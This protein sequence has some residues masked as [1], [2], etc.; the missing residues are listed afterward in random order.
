MKFCL[1]AFWLFLL[2]VGGNQQQLSTDCC[3]GLRPT[4]GM[5]V[6][7]AAAT[8][9]T[10]V[11]ATASAKQKSIE[12]TLMDS[13]GQIHNGNELE[14][15]MKLRETTR[16]TKTES[17]PVIG[18]ITTT[19]IQ[20]QIV[21]DATTLTAAQKS[22]A[23]QTV[24]QAKTSSL[25]LQQNIKERLVS[26]FA[27]EE[28]VDSSPTTTTS[29]MTD[30]DGTITHHPER[31]HLVPDKLQYTKEIQ[32]KQ[33]RLMGITR[34]FQ[35]TSGLREVDQYLGLP[36]A[37]APTG[38]RRF[39]PPGAPLPWQGLKIARHLPPVCPQK[40]PDMSSQNSV[41]ISRGRYKHLTRLMP[42][43]K[44][45]SEDCLYLNL[46]VPHHVALPT[47]SEQYAVLVY[48]HGESF[49]WNSG[50]PYDGSVLAS[51]GGVIVVTVNY[52]L[53][54][55]GFM[56]PSID[57][58]NIANYA[59]LDQMA[60]L[61][62]IKENIA[63]F[64]GDNTRV[65]LMG[66]STGAACVNYLMVSPV[67]S[68]LFHRAI[69]MSGS[70]MS[71]WA[72]SNQS[73]QLTM[74]IAHA[75]D[76]PLSDHEEDDALLEC[77]RQRRYQDIL[78]IPTSFQQFSTSLGPIV[79]G[80]VIPNQPYKVMA[81]NTEYFSRYDL[82]FGITESESYHTL[83][84]LAL[85]EGLRENERDNLLR[86]YMQ[87]RFD[88]RP[89]LALAATLKKYQDMYNNP[90][91]ATNL[92][93]RDVVL[94]ILSDARVVGPLLQTGVFHADVHRRNYMYV[95]GHNSATGPYANLPHSIM[96]E[97]LAF[98][99]GAPLA[100]AG[101]FASHNYS[102]QEKL[103]SEAVMA[104]WTNFVKSG[105]PKAPWKGTFLNSHALEWDRYDLDWPEFNKRSQAYLNI[106]IPPTVG[107]KYRQI[108]MNF[109]NKEL[110]DE[111]NQIAAIQ[112]Q[113]QQ[114]LRG[115]LTSTMPGNEVITGHMS[116]YGPRD[117]GAE[118][119]VRT[120]K[121]LLQDPLATGSEQTETA[122]ENMYNAP[123]TFG[124]VHRQQ[125]GMDVM[126]GSMSG[127]EVTQP[128]QHIADYGEDGTASPSPLPSEPVA[129]SETTMQLLI[130]LIAIFIVLNVAI[131]AT[132]LLRQRRK[133]NTS[134]QRK[135]GGNI[136]SYDGANDDELKRCSKSRDGDDSYVLD[137]VRK[138][139][140]Y[141]AIKTG[142]R[143]P[144]NGY[145]IQRQLSSSTVDT[146]TKVCEW[147]SSQNQGHKLPKSGSFQTTPT[148]PPVAQTDGRI[149]ICQDI[150][151]A[152]AALLTPQHMHE[153][154]ET[155]HYEL[156][157]QRQHS[158]LT[159]PSDAT[160][161]RRHSHSHSDPVDMI[162]AADEQVTSFVHADDVDINVTS[163][164]EESLNLQP[165]TAAQQLDLLR[166]RN[167]P[168]VLPTAQDL[169]SYKRNSLPPQNFV[170]PLPPP[171]TISSTL[172][173]RRRDSSNITTSPLM[174]AQDCGEDEPG[175][176]QI[177]QNTL[178]VGPI[179]PKSPAASLKRP[180]RPTLKPEAQLPGQAVSTLSGSFQS[181][182]SVPP[183]HEATPPQGQRTECV[184]AIAASPSVSSMPSSP[185][186]WSAPNGDLYAQPTKSA[187]RTSLIPRLLQMSPETLPATHAG[188]LVSN[189][190]AAEV[191]TATTTTSVTP[192]RIPQLQRQTSNKDI[193]PQALSSGS[194]SNNTST[195]NARIESTISSASAA[196]NSWCSS[197]SSSSS[198][199]GTVR[200][201]LQQCQQPS[202]SIT[203]CI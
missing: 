6:A 190:S 178:I 133:R 5:P 80:H 22:F 65:T 42:Y 96:G 71:D 185:T 153:T 168:K 165:L 201:E 191:S 183:A 152:D 195:L 193:G 66:H 104:Y 130:A 156:L 95:F 107:Y 105:N 147:M 196:T 40:L 21:P 32:I 161:L 118:D 46:Y 173:R 93:H 74:Q 83:A 7:V 120:L 197:G 23:R 37:E 157:L 141:E 172:G 127:E 38:S 72:A 88:V 61:H 188:Q 177:T 12:Q 122:A 112:L 82:L 106:G 39:M 126:G 77:L 151:V 76:C 86:F 199:T 116:K 113:G 4:W 166:Q 52:R 89:D 99:F 184:Y 192:S 171:R 59:L 43:L 194:D 47:A 164:D 2:T 62:W 24:K 119:P 35:V 54:A 117:N 109:W 50:N 203:T 14:N 114:Q 115:T 121:L 101:P 202:K 51:Y 200:T 124:H 56:R 64:G 60:A 160:L 8:A 48:L 91:K 1:E 162:L 92:E 125:Q 174:L 187:S 135:L 155:M 163:R 30:N 140:T 150:E 181:F 146:H 85:E 180:K 13:G 15:A 69:L 29:A 90:I 134:L 87:T 145:A 175:E 142:Q 170:A 57:A 136:L 67:S 129:K 123:P 17:L 19:T 28:E 100:P 108:Y 55:L 70:A 94:D 53:G 20:S 44:T 25:N 103:L 167:Y 111:L 63:A 33:G 26:L 198:S 49:E 137:M 18:D 182:E 138:S 16:Q 31:R 81:H 143:S 97:E 45:E 10:T 36:Y 34:R 189:P 159:E 79:D 84:A 176:P 132:F 68:G 179:V 78:H 3:H 148:P 27:S 102:V 139:N 144:I 128:G 73:L 58:H 98:I 11:N 186:S 110:P 169:R 9:T 131:Y 154:Q 149:I 158:A 41:N 75:L